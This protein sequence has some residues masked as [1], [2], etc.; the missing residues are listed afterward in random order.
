MWFLRGL[1]HFAAVIAQLLGR[2]LAG[3]FFEL[4]LLELHRVLQ[5]GDAVVLGQHPAA[6]HEH[7]DDEHGGDESGTIHSSSF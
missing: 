1:H 3:L 6:K 4:L 7:D 2:Q 5:L